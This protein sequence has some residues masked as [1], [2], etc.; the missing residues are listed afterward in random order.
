M[1][2]VRKNLIPEAAPQ[3]PE[4]ERERERK[5]E[6]KREKE[7]KEGDGVCHNAR[8]HVTPGTGACMHCSG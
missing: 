5:R 6:A 7:R 8:E 4:R 3:N 2:A 1:L